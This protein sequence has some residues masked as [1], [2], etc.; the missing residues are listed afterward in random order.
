MKKKVIVTVIEM[1]KP[2]QK[3][4]TVR[5]RQINSGFCRTIN[6]EGNEQYKRCN[7]TITRY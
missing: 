7:S 1:V 5:H 2:N 6:D 3:V 4:V